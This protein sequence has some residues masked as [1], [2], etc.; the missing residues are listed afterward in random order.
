MFQNRSDGREER[1]E[2]STSGR[3][4]SPG[5]PDK[6]KKKL[7]RVNYPPTK[8]K[9]TSYL[10]LLHG[11]HR[12]TQRYCGKTTPQHRNLPLNFLRKKKQ[13]KK[14]FPELVLSTSVLF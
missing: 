7:A 3:N 8:D 10:S 13:G 9:D 1:V 4:T 14:K 5:Y 11:D 2:F 12:Y 6:V